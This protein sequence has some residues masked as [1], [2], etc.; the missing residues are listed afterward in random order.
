LAK[1]VKL[2]LRA[3]SRDAP[4][5]LSPAPLDQPSCA[6][7]AIERRAGKVDDGIGNGRWISAS[8]SPSELSA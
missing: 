6:Q 4:V 8:S 7:H 2:A 5:N 1:R 3:P